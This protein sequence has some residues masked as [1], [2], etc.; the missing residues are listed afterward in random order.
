[1]GRWHLFSCPATMTVTCCR[2]LVTLTLAQYLT[3]TIAGEVV[4]GLVSC[5]NNEDCVGANRRC[6]HNK[7]SLTGLCICREGYKPLL[8]SNTIG[9][10]KRP[11]SG[12]FCDED[13][14]CSHGDTCMIVKSPP[15][16]N[17]RLTN[18]EAESGGSEE[19]SRPQHN[20]G[21][22]ICI[23]TWLIYPDDE[24]RTGGGLRSSKFYPDDFF[25]R[26][27]R[28]H[29]Q[30][31]GFV[32]DMMLILFLIC[33]L[34]TLVTVHRASCYRQFQ[35]ARRNSPLRH[36][37]PIADDQPPPYI[38]RQSDSV[39]GLGEVVV[40]EATAPKRQSETPPPTYEEALYRNTVVLPLERGEMIPDL[41]ASSPASLDEDACLPSYH[42]TRQGYQ[43]QDKFTSF[44]KEM[45]DLDEVA[46][47]TTTAGSAQQAN[48]PL[49]GPINTGGPST[50]PITPGVPSAGPISSG[51]PSAGPLPANDD[52]DSAPS[53]YSA[54][55]SSSSLP[56]PLA[57]RSGSSATSAVGK[58]SD[59]GGGKGEPAWERLICSGTNTP[60]IAAPTSTTTPAANLS[61]P[62]G[63]GQILVNYDYTMSHPMSQEPP[64]FS[65]D[66]I[67]AAATA[68]AREKDDALK[69]HPDGGGPT[70]A[71]PRPDNNHN[72]NNED[73]DDAP[74][75][76][77]RMMAPPVATSEDGAMAESLA[78]RLPDPL[79]NPPDC[80]ASTRE[81]EN[82]AVEG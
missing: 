68:A 47:A 52:Q 12:H 59:F 71:P 3:L 77:P 43:D 54:D 10:I 60:T 66:V 11:F 22:G 42:E 61:R 51:G 2:L 49:T 53:I 27:P 25:F 50:G 29:Q 8:G 38:S 48:G 69:D 33:I 13:A 78:R 62:L 82:F 45:A 57:A 56:E 1:M 75:T 40:E 18:N 35:D 55:T 19:Q 14:D 73:N 17:Q 41:H 70:N 65:Y 4:G 58:S 30:Y 20:P 16:F 79:A 15:H 80:C 46:P 72:N 23:S 37:L 26:R 76:T 32:E 36:I 67:T 31:I 6:L 74:T 24:P 7:T 64:L 44:A 9:C 5:M 21:A 63:I 39:D 28:V 34:V 81:A